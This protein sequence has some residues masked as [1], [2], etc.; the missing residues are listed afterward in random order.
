MKIFK[1]LKQVLILFISI[2]YFI[3]GFFYAKTTHKYRNLHQ[4]FSKSKKPKTILEVLIK[5]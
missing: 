2:I 1:T 3:E 5:S 4:N